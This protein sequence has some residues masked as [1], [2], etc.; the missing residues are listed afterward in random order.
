MHIQNWTPCSNL[1]N[2]HRK[3]FLTVSK[4]A[5]RPVGFS[6]Y[7]GDEEERQ[8]KLLR[9]GEKK[10]VRLTVDCAV[11]YDLADIVNPVS[12]AKDPAAV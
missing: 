1:A 2:S 4:T 12:L 5:D 10:G 3:W 6:S 8:A 7:A 9:R 11:A